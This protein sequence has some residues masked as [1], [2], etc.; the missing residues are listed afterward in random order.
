MHDNSADRSGTPPRRER[1]C[2]GGTML[3]QRDTRTLAAIVIQPSRSRH[4]GPASDIGRAL[5]GDVVNSTTAIP[6]PRGGTCGSDTVT[7]DAGLA[8]ALGLF[9]HGRVSDRADGE[10][11]VQET[12]VRLLGYPSARVGDAKALCFSIARNLLFDRHR[13]AARAVQV[14]LDDDLVCPQPIAEVVVAFRRAV[15][16]LVA[17]LER[18]PPLRREVFLRRRL[19]GATTAEIAAALDM[20]PAAIEKHVTR[21]AGDLREALQ[22]RGFTMAHG[23]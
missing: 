7:I 23:A 21:A 5:A 15:A 16:I 10:D 11:I 1:G 22:R 9:V 6:A 20:S 3:R 14:E 19:D 18:M 12:F 13:A 17:A 2:D 4:N 8:R